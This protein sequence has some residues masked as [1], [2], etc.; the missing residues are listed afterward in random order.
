MSKLA[1]FE[2][3]ELAVDV[4]DEVAGGTW[5]WGGVSVRNNRFNVVSQS[6]TT[7]VSV[8]GS[9]N[10]VLA[11]SSNYISGVIAAV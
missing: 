11:S 10:L 3:S 7:N 5:G 2:G 9:N 6:A 1:Q 8:K 4:L